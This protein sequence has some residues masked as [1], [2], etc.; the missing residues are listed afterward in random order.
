MF[1]ISH[2]TEI[3]NDLKVSKCQSKMENQQF[4]TRWG[5]K[6]ETKFCK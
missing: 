2:V 6:G 1:V 5:Q 4:W 3:L